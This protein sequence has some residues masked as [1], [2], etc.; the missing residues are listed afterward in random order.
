MSNLT[1]DCRE[2]TTDVGINWDYVGVSVIIQFS[3]ST[4][5]WWSLVLSFNRGASLRRL[6]VPDVSGYFVYV[7]VVF[8]RVVGAMATRTNDP[9][10]QFSM[11]LIASSLTWFVFVLIYNNAVAAPTR[12]QWLALPLSLVVTFLWE[13][14]NYVI[15][16][17][18]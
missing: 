16:N 1:R 10:V 12:Q 4:L 6:S 15:V 2:G 8:V 9:V 5:W 11:S 7:F 14:Q 18:L 13:C 3:I 17:L